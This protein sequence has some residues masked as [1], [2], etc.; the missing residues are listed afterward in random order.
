MGT[1]R[2]FINVFPGSK[3]NR[4]PAK[5]PSRD[6]SVILS[7]AAV[8]HQ[9]AEEA[10]KTSV[11]VTSNSVDAGRTGK[12]A[13]RTPSILDNAEAVGIHKLHNVTIISASP[14]DV[15]REASGGIAVHGDVAGLYPAF[16]DKVVKNSS[17]FGG[18]Q[19]HTA[20]PAGTGDALKRDSSTDRFPLSLVCPSQDSIKSSRKSYDSVSNQTIFFGTLDAPVVVLQ[21]HPED[22][23]CSDRNCPE[24]S[25]AKCA[26]R[27]AEREGCLNVKSIRPD[28]TG[29][30][31]Q[32][33]SY[34]R[35]SVSK[36][37][38]NLGFIGSGRKWGSVGHSKSN[39]HSSRSRKEPGWE[40]GSNEMVDQVSS[41]LKRFG[42]TADTLAAL[43]EYNTKLG[44]Y[45]INEVLKHQR[46]P[47]V[48]WEFFNWA[49]TQRGYKHDVR[50]YTTMIGILGRV[51]DFDS[52][53]KL[54][55]NMRK[56]GCEPS[57]VTFNRLIHSYG[58]AN[59]LN[60]ALRIFHHMQD[61][62][63]EPDRV[64]YCT[65]I[66]LHSKSGLHDIAMEICEK[67]WL[68]GFEPD[69][70]SYTL[71]IHCLGKAGN[72]P[73]ANKLFS[74]MIDRGCTPN[75]VTYNI[76][77]DLHA[78]AGKYHMALKL[79]NDMQD[80][81]HRP[82]KV[83]YNVI[84]EVLGHSGNPNEAEDV[85][86]EMVR[87]GWTGDSLTFGLLVNM[88][89]LAGNVE[90]A[91]EWFMKMLD[92]GLMPN[93]PTITSLLGAYLRAHQYEGAMHV[94]HSLAKW[95]LTPT[96]PTYI[97][98]LDSCTTC[99]RR[100]DVESVLHLMRSSGH[101]AHFFLRHVLDTSVEESKAHIQHFFQGLRLEDQETKRGFADALIEFLCRTEHKAK[102]GHVWEVAMENN[103]Y[104]LAISQKVPNSWT[105]DL[106]VMSKGTAVVALSRTLAT[107]R[108]RM[109]STG[110]VPEKIEIV[111][112]W[113]KHSRVSGFSLV[114]NAVQ[115]MLGALG[116][117]FY[118]DSTN[119][120]C[121]VGAGQPLAEWLHQP[122]MDHKLAL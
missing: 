96:L 85:F 119:A 26:Q 6:V 31:K 9:I 121:F 98:L 7:S 80:A 51:R 4:N 2:I 117:P 41:I 74:E 75:L 23:T 95:G 5:I 58:R 37:E 15:G 42:W 65:L 59:N 25:V 10:G 87:E 38:L 70:F 86:Y 17:A 28:G 78:K 67:M 92:T 43:A 14:K 113:G 118:I 114:K 12:S 72:L 83:T 33:G 99:D 89:G 56:E 54:L 45:H 24:A 1:A 35:N 115:N 101:P 46:E 62:G 44:A 34:S 76:M 110:V 111:T 77:I 122:D 61:V 81:G 36:G 18:D 32:L 50:T 39:F 120:G 100:E 103:L 16:R 73:A 49:K 30:Q 91:R 69:T 47:F 48:A 40:N 63:C 90:K 97:L 21:S 20:V 13:E 71:I 27:E 79:Y 88:W 66:D 68:V 60:E 19:P 104:P 3:T 105:V 11:N 82:D 53:N 108:E 8:K 112:G 116:S 29:V 55:Q 84:M 52:C 107:L 57:V 109:L 22:V 93:A 64:T 94:L 102:A 106:H